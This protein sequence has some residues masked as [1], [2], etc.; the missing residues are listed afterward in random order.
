MKLKILL[1]TLFIIFFVLSLNAQEKKINTKVEQ[2]PKL[3]S[4]KKLKDKEAEKCTQEGIHEFIV[5]NFTYPIEAI[6]KD[7]EGKVYVRF[8]VDQKGNVTDVDIAKG[9][10]KLLNDAAIKLIEKLPKFI[11][12]KQ[13]GKT[14]KVQYVIPLNYAIKR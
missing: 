5:K 2:M 8:I 9:A 10:D 6:D 1:N 13:D 12:G 11:P 7:I 3:K 4:C 14:V